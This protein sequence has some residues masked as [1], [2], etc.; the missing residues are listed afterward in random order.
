MIPPG[1]RP[2]EQA[3]V[4]IY[5]TS[6]SGFVEEIDTDE[7]HLI[8]EDSVFI[9]RGVIHLNSQRVDMS[10]PIQNG[11]VNTISQSFAAQR[12]IA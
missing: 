9:P 1:P 8:L 6:A 7:M 4:A 12:P 10:V 11:Y 3:L 2:E 5:F